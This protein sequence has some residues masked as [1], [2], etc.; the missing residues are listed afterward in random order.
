MSSV[1]QTNMTKAVC[2]ESRISV[3]IANVAGASDVSRKKYIQM[4]NVC[5]KIDISRFPCDS[6]SLDYHNTLPSNFANK[7]ENN[8]S[9]HG[10][11]MLK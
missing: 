7:F 9:P 3:S 10:Q 1:G 6:S 8:F 2:Y 5:M 4:V 11:I